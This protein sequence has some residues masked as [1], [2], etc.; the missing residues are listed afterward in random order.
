MSGIKGEPGD[1]GDVSAVLGTD[2]YTY[3]ANQ[4]PNSNI[5][6]AFKNGRVSSHENSLSN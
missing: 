1:R 5:R 2:I 4:K 3:V 6:H